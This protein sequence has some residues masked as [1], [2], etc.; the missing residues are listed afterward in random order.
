MNATRKNRRREMRRRNRDVMQN[1]MV[2]RGWE[3]VV[4]VTNAV[5]EFGIVNKDEQRIVVRRWDVNKLCWVY[6]ATSIGAQSGKVRPCDWNEMQAAW[7]RTMRAV[8]I[9]RGWL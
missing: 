4:V 8:L 1:T 9:E 7:M 6:F 2:L 5:A 3:P